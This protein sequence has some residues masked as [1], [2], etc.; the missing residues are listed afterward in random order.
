M[1]ADQNGNLVWF[2]PLPAGEG[3]TNF[4]VQ[5]YDGKPVLTWWQGESCRSGFGQGEDVIYDT[6][7]QQ[8]AH[9]PCGQRLPRRPARDP[10]HPAGHRVDRR[11]RPDPHEP[12]LRAR[13]LR[14]RPHRL[15]RAGDRRQDRPRDVGVARDRAHRRSPNRT[16]PRP[17]SSYPWD[18]VHVNSVD[19]GNSSDVLLSARNTWTLYDVDIHSGGCRL[20]PR[21]RAQQLQARRGHALLLAARRR[22]PARRADLACSTTARTRPRRSSRAAC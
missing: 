13:P 22:V 11:V 10:A 16:T 18:Y 8:V 4:E 6:S 5:Q 17:T 2:H 3:A 21:R 14:R 1:I 12:V 15:D 7:Y 20:A 9:G 19:P